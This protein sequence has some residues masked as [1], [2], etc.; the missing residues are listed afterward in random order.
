M[1]DKK[2]NKLPELNSSHFRFFVAQ[3]LFDLAGKVV[4]LILALGIGGLIYLAIDSLADKTTLI[5]ANILFSLFISKDNDYALP[6]I[7]SLCC[8]V[9]AAGERWLRHWKTEA[10]QKHIKELE[11]QLDPLRTSS[12]LTPTGETNPKDK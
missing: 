10:L 11:L 3:G 8:L 5:D 7:F 2:N 9:W 6:W 4:N 12:G 1:E